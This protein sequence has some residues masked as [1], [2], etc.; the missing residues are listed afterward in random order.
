MKAL[1]LLGLKLLYNKLAC[2]D[3]KRY[4]NK[5]YP[6]YSKVGRGV[7]LSCLFNEVS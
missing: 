3:N 6:Y 2:S 1:V 7:V 5:V 4:V